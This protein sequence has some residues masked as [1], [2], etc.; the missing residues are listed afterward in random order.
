MKKVLSILMVAFAMTAMVACGD[1]NEST[2]N[3]GGNNGGG[4]GGGTNPGTEQTD[5]LSDTYWK[6]IEGDELMIDPYRSVSFDCRKDHYCFYWD[7]NHLNEP[8]EYI[9]GYGTYT[10]DEATS[11]GTATLKN[12]DND[13]PMGTATFTVNGNEMQFTFNGHTYAMIKGQ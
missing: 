2:D 11:S 1:K 12:Q 8:A 6:Y 4:G 13:Q 5:A 3:G 9:S 7:N 10:Y